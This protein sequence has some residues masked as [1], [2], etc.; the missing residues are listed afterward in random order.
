M[1]QS[2]EDP[3]GISRGAENPS[4][5]SSS[6][7]GTHSSGNGSAQ[8]QSANAPRGEPFEPLT[9]VD[10]SKW[11]ELEPTKPEYAVPDR[12]PAKQVTLF[13]GEGGTG[14]ERVLRNIWPRSRGS[15]RLDAGGLTAL[16]AE[17]ESRG[18]WGFPKPLR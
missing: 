4:S 17:S 9:F 2:N 13:T 7:G 12:V 10:T 8:D 6:N 5:S 1:A 15:L 3:A 11:D 14:K 16:S 18:I